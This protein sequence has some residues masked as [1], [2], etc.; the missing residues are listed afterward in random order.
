MPDHAAVVTDTLWKSI[1]FMNIISTKN[2]S[3][4]IETAKHDQLPDNASDSISFDAC[5]SARSLIAKRLQTTS[6]D[7]TGI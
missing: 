7:S 3:S 5:L 1:R 4:N 2:V 6:V